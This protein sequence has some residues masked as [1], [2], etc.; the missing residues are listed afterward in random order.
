MAENPR[1]GKKLTA[2]CLNDVDTVWDS[3]GRSPKKSLR[4]R[5]QE[6]DLSRASFHLYPYRIQ[7]KHKL[8]PADLEFLGINH[9]Q[10]GCIFF[11]TP[12]TTPWFLAEVP[13][14]NPVFFCCNYASGT[15]KKT[16]K[17]QKKQKQKNKN[18][19]TIRCLCCCISP[20]KIQTKKNF[21]L[22]DGKL[23]KQLL[24]IICPEETSHLILI[25]KYPTLGNCT[26]VFFKVISK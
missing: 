13:S 14:H 22:W 3:V 17:K 15:I 18:K 1:S 19:K 20:K 2:R 7:I 26:L 12:C 23:N 11:E 24:R 21:E 25:E 6:L 16:T 4:R 5:S 10:M 9:Y 8:T